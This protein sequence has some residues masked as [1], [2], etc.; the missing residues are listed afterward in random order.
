MKHTAFQLFW[1]VSLVV[2]ACSACKAEDIHVEAARVK[3]Q[4]T[5]DL[6]V[7]SSRN[8]IEHW[9]DRRGIEHSFDQNDNSIYSMIRE[10]SRN[11]YTYKD[12]T[13]NIVGDIQIIF[14]LDEKESLHGIEV[15]PIFTGP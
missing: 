13:F 14:R 7:G 12:F 1:L 15:K 10:A 6:A 8:A 4:L 2:L 11:K 5:H 9:L 3:A